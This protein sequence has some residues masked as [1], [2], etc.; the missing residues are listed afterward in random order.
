MEQE[1]PAQQAPA[2]TSPSRFNPVGAASVSS[3]G[4]DSEISR[5]LMPPCYAGTRL[6]A[7]RAPLDSSGT[8][9]QHSDY[10]RFS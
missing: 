8:R 5:V 6:M 9:G 4:T 7:S 3:A 1:S 2:L 10:E